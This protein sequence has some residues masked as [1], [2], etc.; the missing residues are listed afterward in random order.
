MACLPGR[1]VTAW[2]TAIMP[3]RVADFYM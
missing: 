1:I 2:T 3:C